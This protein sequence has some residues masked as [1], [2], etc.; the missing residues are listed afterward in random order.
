ME[1]DNNNND[2]VNESPLA[3]QDRVLELKWHTIREYLRVEHFAKAAKSCK[4]L[5]RL[6]LHPSTRQIVT[7][8][9]ALP[10]F[11]HRNTGIGTCEVVGVLCS[12]YL[13]EVKDIRVDLRSQQPYAAF[14]S[15]I[16]FLSSC[17][18]LESLSMCFDRSVGMSD[19]NASADEQ[20]V[21]L[22]RLALTFRDMLMRSEKLT[23]LSIRT[24]PSSNRRHAVYKHVLLQ[25]ICESLRANKLKELRL[26]VC[27]LMLGNIGLA[28]RFSKA[29]K[30][31]IGSAT[32]M[33]S[34]SLSFDNATGDEFYSCGSRNGL[35]VSNPF[36]SRMNLR[37]LA[38]QSE[39]GGINQWPTE[40][41]S[42]Y[43]L[44]WLDVFGSSEKLEELEFKLGDEFPD[45]APG[46]SSKLAAYFERM[47]HIR[48]IDV[49]LKGKTD[50]A[51]AQALAA[52]V[53]R[54]INWNYLFIS[55][56]KMAAGTAE[57]LRMYLDEANRNATTPIYLTCNRDPTFVARNLR[58]DLVAG[59]AEGHVLLYNLSTE[60]DGDDI[61]TDT[62]LRRGACCSLNM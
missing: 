37:R 20:R 60:S 56:F 39:D 57:D 32:R 11:P 40:E 62:D 43:N 38:L 53:K 54:N 28:K 31:A 7:S 1:I 36:T 33:A 50:D 58:G 30:E 15:F 44:S 29:L 59:E 45:D 21:Q 52:L 16:G 9:F 23:C 49:D 8:S 3:K 51:V 19:E 42:R 25:S 6:I 13:P 18:S 27:G 48:R 34:L 26:R 14:V 55:G 17:S 10:C 5:R 4:L 47:E 61:S 22:G 41:E 24:R 12:L 35:D 2:D 46:F